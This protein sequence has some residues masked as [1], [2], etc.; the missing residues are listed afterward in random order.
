MN[1]WSPYLA[2][3]SHDSKL[4]SVDEALKHN[5][6][7]HVDVVVVHVLPQMES[8]V[9]LCN[10]NDRLDVTNSDWNT[11]SSLRT[12]KHM[13][14]KTGEKKVQAVIWKHINTMSGILA[15]LLAVAHTN[16][17]RPLFLR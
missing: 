7:G 5:A 9:G 15:I 8:S 16:T 6:D 11:A 3:V 4:L 2:H 10:A 17:I 12:H 1:T 13:S 14:Y